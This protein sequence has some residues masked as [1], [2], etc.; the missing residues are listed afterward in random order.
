M[1]SNSLTEYKNEKLKIECSHALFGEP[2]TDL[3]YNIQYQSQK[4]VGFSP[5]SRILK[6]CASSIH[7]NKFSPEVSPAA[8]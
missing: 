3:S 5:L 1:P 6:K 8:C 7:A 4:L 2:L